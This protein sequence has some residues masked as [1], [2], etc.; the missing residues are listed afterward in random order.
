MY[1]TRTLEHTIEQAVASFPA[2]VVSGPRQSGK[3]TLLRHLFAGSH[4]FVTLEDLDVRQQAVEDPRGFLDVYA[5]PVILDEI[6]YV[7]QLLSYIKTRIDEDRTPGQWLFTGS[8][9]FPLM[10]G[11][12]QSLAGRV[13]LLQL[14]P[15]NMAE[16]MRHGRKSTAPGA[17][18]ERIH[19]R[20]T[21]HWW[22]AAAVLDT[23][24]WVLDG[25]YPEPVVNPAVSRQLWYSSYIT[26]YIERDVRQLVNVGDVETFGRFVR[27]CAGLAGRLLNRSS[28]AS[29]C[30][31]SVPTVKRWLSVLEASGIIFF[32]RPYFRNFGKRLIKAPKLY[33]YDTGLACWLCGLHD[34]D[35]LVGHSDYGRLFENAVIAELRKKWMHTAGEPEIWFMRTPDGAEIDCVLSHG[36]QLYLF[37]I[38][39][40]KTLMPKHGA[41]CVHWA[42][43]LGSHSRIGGLIAPV[44]DY[45]PI[46]KGVVGIPWYAL[47]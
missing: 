9:V 5:P 19:T 43:E 44:S 42:H 15:F 8:Q 6:Q 45:V 24:A 34:S 32:L 33:F 7:P 25:G 22:P 14:W 2:V 11:V 35:A 29:D 46:R 36:G 47:V 37:E 26:T 28:L 1:Y 16:R 13:A 27:L 40:T 39:S 3:T 23:A 18:L 30:G 12:R 41:A 4:R 38:K 20:S 10:E 31:V 17:F 21:P